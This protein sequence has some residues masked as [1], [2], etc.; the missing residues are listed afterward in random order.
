MA[1]VWTYCDESNEVY[2]FRGWS[3]EHSQ[4][5]WCQRRS[6]IIGGWYPLTTFGYEKEGKRKKINRTFPSFF[7]FQ[8]YALK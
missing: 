1:F 7:M 2:M 3:L 8:I 6:Y 4:G 5:A